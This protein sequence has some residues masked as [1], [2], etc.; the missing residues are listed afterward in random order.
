MFVDFKNVWD[1]GR[2]KLPFGIAQIGKSFRNEIT[3]RQLHLPHPRVRAD[4]DG[5]LRQART[6]TEDKWH[7]YWIDTRCRQWL[8]STSDCTSRTTLRLFEHPKE[9]LSH[10]SKR[11]VDIEYKFNYRRLRSSAEL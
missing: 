8:T 4:G 2:V 3:P 10:Y 6:P 11:T 9:K 1:T 7:Q 5:V